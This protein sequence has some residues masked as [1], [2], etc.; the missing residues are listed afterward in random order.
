MVYVLSDSADVFYKCT[1]Y[2]QLGD[3]ACIRWD[4]SILTIDCPLS[5]RWSFSLS[6]KHCQAP[7]LSGEFKHVPRFHILLLIT[8]RDI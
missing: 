2:Y 1:N 4:S 7:I 5:E 8:K 6:D 3:E